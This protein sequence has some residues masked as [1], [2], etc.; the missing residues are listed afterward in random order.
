MLLKELST[1]FKEMIQARLEKVNL[2]DYVKLK[3]C[4]ACRTA[5]DRQ[6]QRALKEGE[7]E[8]PY[9]IRPVTEKRKADVPSL[10]NLTN[11]TERYTSRVPFD[12]A[13]LPSAELPPERAGTTAASSKLLHPNVTLP[14]SGDKCF[15]PYDM[16]ALI[17]FVAGN[18][19]A[20]RRC[21]KCGTEGPLKVVMV[22]AAQHDH[23]ATPNMALVLPCGHAVKDVQFRSKMKDGGLSSALADA[24]H[25]AAG[26]SSAVRSR[27][28]AATTAGLRQVVDRQA[29]TR[30]VGTE[31][32]ET[33]L[34]TGGTHASQSLSQSQD[35]AAEGSST[36]LP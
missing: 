29:A 22:H 33:A 18:A 21:A 17:N 10:T 25:L 6:A 19:G 32:A 5:L 28:A 9:R 1:E 24:L 7:G 26:P 34:S 23:T 31:A 4:A 8:E 35:A 12:S 11:G 36:V 27:R 20:C 13:F 30:S 3:M 15:T 14:G 2:E 16:V